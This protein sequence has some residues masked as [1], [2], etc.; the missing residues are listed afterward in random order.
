MAVTRHKNAR[1]KVKIYIANYLLPNQV[2][3]VLQVALNSMLKFYLLH[4]NT[5]PYVEI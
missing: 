1:I 3:H 2:T 5:Q 4:E